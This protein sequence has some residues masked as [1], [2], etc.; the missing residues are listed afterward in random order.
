MLLLVGVACVSA[1]SVNNVQDK[2]SHV[3][4]IDDDDGSVSGTYK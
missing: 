3:Q 4:E 1:M 2:F